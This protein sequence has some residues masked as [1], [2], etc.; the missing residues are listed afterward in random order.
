MDMDIH[1]L[2]L[3]INGMEMQL[4]SQ[5]LVVVMMDLL[6]WLENGISRVLKLKFLKSSENKQFFLLGSDC[7]G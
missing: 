2:E 1:I 7:C 3:E 6:F 4:V 5:H